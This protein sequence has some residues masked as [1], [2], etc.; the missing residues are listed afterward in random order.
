MEIKIRKPLCFSEIGRKDNQEDYLWPFEATTKQRVFIMCDG[1]GG[2][3]SGEV[4]SQTAATALGEWLTANWP[5]DGIVTKEIFE[6]ALS[7][8]YDALDNVD[9]ADSES[10]RKMGTTM[11]CVVLHEGGVLAAHI[12]DSRI[13]QVR[14]SL[15]I[16]QDKGILYQSWDHSLVNDL[17]RAGE[18]TEEEMHNFPRKNVITRAMQP[19][20]ERR[21]KADIHSL[22]DIQSGDYLFL[23]CD[24]VLERLTNDDLRHILASDATDEKKLAAI[25]AICD[26]GTRDNY[27]CWLVP[28]DSVEGAIPSTDDEEVSA[29]E[30]EAVT[31]EDETTKTE[32]TEN[33]TTEVEDTATTPAVTSRIAP[34]LTQQKQTKK[35]PSLRLPILLLLALIGFCAWLAHDRF[36]SS[37]EEADTLKV[38]SATVA[39]PI[40]TPEVKTDTPKIEKPQEADDVAGE[41]KEESKVEG[42]TDPQPVEASHE[43][44]TADT[45]AD[46]K[47]PANKFNITKKGDGS[48]N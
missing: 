26:E 20:L 42:K 8:A 28:I 16:E 4:A 18:L 31:A 11:T 44:A 12:G 21:C 33:E 17:F 19:H 36:F 2:Q 30:V 14:P 46:S 15:V 9:T 48:A 10:V 23:C 47:K 7:H 37:A 38:D 29:I 22:T 43:A 5:E 1:V 13:Y 6:E 39:P 27:T 40:K 35:A 3:D 24:G 41:A 45:K 32:E 25:K 34:V